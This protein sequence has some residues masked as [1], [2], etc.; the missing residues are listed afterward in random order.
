MNCPICERLAT[1]V[2]D[3]DFGYSWYCHPCEFGFTDRDASK[4]RGAIQ[5]PPV[6]RNRFRSIM[7][8]GTKCW[9]MTQGEYRFLAWRCG[10]GFRLRISTGHGMDEISTNTFQGVI[11]HVDVVLNSKERK[12]DEKR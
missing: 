6:R 3:E 7:S 9:L 4:I 12:I 8:G 5:N 1:S 11:R 10:H 2:Y